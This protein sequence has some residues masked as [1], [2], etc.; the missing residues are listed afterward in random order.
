VEALWKQEGAKSWRQYAASPRQEQT[1][2]RVAWAAV[3]KRYVKVGDAW[4]ERP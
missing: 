2:H 3:K 1:A 4:V